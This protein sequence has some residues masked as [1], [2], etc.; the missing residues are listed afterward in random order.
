VVGGGSGGGRAGHGIALSE[1]ARGYP[2][3]NDASLLAWDAELAALG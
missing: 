2:A 1:P 3:R